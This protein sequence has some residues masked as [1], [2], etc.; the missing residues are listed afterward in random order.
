MRFKWHC[1]TIDYTNKKGQSEHSL[2]SEQNEKA[3]LI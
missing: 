3:E 1:R 2:A